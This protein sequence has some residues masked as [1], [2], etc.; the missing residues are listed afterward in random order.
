[1]RDLIDRFT[2]ELRA[3][4]DQRDDLL[5]LTACADPDVGI[6]LKVL[7][8]LDRAAPS[9]LFLLL[10]D[11]FTDARSFVTQAVER[12]REEHRLAC[13]ARTADGQKPF[14]PL[15]AGL[16]DAARPPEDRL[17]EAMAFTRSLLPPAGGNRLVWAM[18]PT[19]VADWPA[20]LK[21]V[22]SCT[23]REGVKPWM[24]GLRLI[25]RARADFAFRTSPLVD[26]ERTRLTKIDF[27]PAALEASYQKAAADPKLPAAERMDALLSVALLASARGLEPGGKARLDEA[28]RHFQVLLAHH[29]QAD[30]P[31]M[32]AV[33]LNGLGDIEHREGNLEKAR[34]WYECAVPPA[35]KAEQPIVLAAVVQNLAAV[36]YR[37]ARYD[38]AEEYYDGLVTLKNAV[39][40]EDGK[41]GALEWR[42][43]SQE[44]QNS[45]DRAVLSWEEAKLLSRAFELNYRL[46]PV[47]EHLQRAYRHLRQS[48]KLKAVEADLKEMKA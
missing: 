6:A 5:L 44:K 10:A 45:Y 39:L 30:N 23:P 9:D 7:R 26:A 16:A 34:H 36:S 21:L 17:H 22:A 18:L 37:Q 32:Q 48:E 20:Y 2:R 11:D 4:I 19:A 47:L 24:R 8:D 28:R 29:Q 1:M 14:P 31:L 35:A 3:F 15:P 43:L 38:E 25:F 13:E 27:G 42:G 40:D 12:L 41:V 46:R 33:V